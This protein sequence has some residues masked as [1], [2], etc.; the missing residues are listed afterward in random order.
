MESIETWNNFRGLSG[1]F[2]AIGGIYLFYAAFLLVRMNF[3]NEYALLLTLTISINAIVFLA[4]AFQL[5]KGNY[6]LYFVSVGIMILSIPIAFT[7]IYYF[8]I[9]RIPFLG[10]GRYFFFLIRILILISII[11]KGK[12]VLDAMKTSRTS[13]R[14]DILDV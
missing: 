8:D 11:R 13:Q 3:N 7:E 4:T 5:K 6:T 12:E 9:P 2:Y 14:E 10:I 1:I